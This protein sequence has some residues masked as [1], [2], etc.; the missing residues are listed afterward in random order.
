MGRPRMRAARS[1]Q[2]KDGGAA[3]RVFIKQKQSS[4]HAVHTVWRAESKGYA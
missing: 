2:L 1:H 4:N 3:S